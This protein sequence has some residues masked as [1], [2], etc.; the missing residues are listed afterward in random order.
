MGT[1][2]AVYTLA[3]STYPVSLEL[4]WRTIRSLLHLLFVATTSSQLGNV[5]E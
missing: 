2:L 1:M 3:Y 5:I 4:A